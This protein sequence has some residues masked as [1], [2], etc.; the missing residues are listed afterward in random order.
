VGSVDDRRAL[1]RS[2]G[3]VRED[4]GGDLESLAA[5]ARDVRG[6]PYT[7]E[8]AFV[9]KHGGRLLRVANRGFAVVAGEGRIWALVAYDE[10]D[11][12][13]LLW[14]ALAIADAPPRV[15]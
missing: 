4:D 7:S 11:A 6:A 5:L 10:E 15:R 8:L 14:H 12:R 13:A 2:F 1:P 9:L 3:T